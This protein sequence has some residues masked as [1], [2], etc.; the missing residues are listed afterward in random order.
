MY[1]MDRDAICIQLHPD[2]SY[3]CP[4]DWMQLTAEI[5]A[6]CQVCTFTALM[7]RLCCRTKHGE[8]T[9]RCSIVRF[10]WSG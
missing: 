4:N 10:C 6:S 3:A 8:G 1:T 7:S 5:A 2:E 9:H